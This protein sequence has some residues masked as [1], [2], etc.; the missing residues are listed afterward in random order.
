MN[1]LGIL[2]WLLAS[3]RGLLPVLGVSVLARILQQLLGV[4]LLV[5]A[6]AAVV[7][8]EPP[9]WALAG[10]LV[11]I[12][13]LKAGLRYLE[14]Y[15]GHWVA[16]TALQRLRELFFAR[17]APQAPAAT[18]GRA[19]AELTERA[20]R[21]IDR[22]E[23]FF[24]HTMPP[25]VSALAVP[26]VALLWLGL[27]VDGPLALVLAPFAA[28]AVALPFLAGGASWRGARLVAE[29]RGALA[30]RIGDDL[31][32]VREVL[33]FGIQ[34]RRLDA[35]DAADRELT[36]ARSRA[37]AIQGARTAGVTAL[38]GGSLVAVIA[39]ASDGAD[40][41]LALAVA[42]G[43]W[44]PLRGVDAFASGL[45][46]A[47]AAAGRVREVVDAAP[48]VLD[49]VPMGSDL[50][51]PAASARG[52]VVDGV[53]LTYPGRPSPA[54]DGV[55]LRLAAGAWSTVVGVSGSG[56]S[57]LGALLLRGWDP[58]TGVVALDGVGL[59]ELPLDE[60]RR[61]VALA[62]QRPVLLSGT[63]ASNLRLAAPDAPEELLRE[64]L[65]TVDLDAWVDG[66]PDGMETVLRERGTEVSG[67]QRQRL[68][69]ARALVAGPEV[70]VL[71]EALS[72]LDAATA[73]TVRSRLIEHHPGLTIVEIT[74]RADLVPDDSAVV[75]LDAGR[76]VE[77]GLAGELR[78]AGGAFGRIEARAV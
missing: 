9:T 66:L 16:F 58:D 33:G 25:A 70:L 41:V 43:L 18:Q 11:A 65:R 45:D 51:L 62:P 52:I 20:T 32:G 26:L 24:A 23:V 60:L 69:L 54:L 46:A 55:S 36:S 40:A 3:I 49:R 31:Q 64:A 74:H 61:R 42:V 14:Q 39:V 10:W 35:I 4:A 34:R 7:A 53:S 38:L 1:R 12:A 28:L 59:R 15:A 21:D 27:V 6:A 67:G 50:G 13:L 2:R 48:R 17:L 76:V 47:F 71:D 8:G 56:K 30:A 5:M 72:Q 37:G 19:G 75:V 63:I 68:A 22:V 44:T 73:A 29:R 57:T 78:A 77:T